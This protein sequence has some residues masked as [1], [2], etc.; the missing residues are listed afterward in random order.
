MIKLKNVLSA[1]VMIVAVGCVIPA[2]AQ[3]S[4]ASAAVKK[5][6]TKIFQKALIIAFVKDEATRKITE[7][8]FVEELKGRGIASYKYLGTVDT[9]TSESVL[10]D[11]LKQDGFD[12]VVLIK[13]ATVD[14]TKQAAPGNTSSS[15]SSWYGAYSNTYP[16]FANPSNYPV[17]KVYNVEIN[18]YSLVT[19]KLIW[20]GTTSAVNTSNTGR[21]IDQVITMTKQQMKSQ[22]FIK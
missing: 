14:Q 12:G 11:K 2:S 9:R 8:K 18:V 3:D 4:P 13:L 21:M 6:S 15:G 22:G 16:M 1:V 20:R 19:D 5:D 17:G 7:D 10:S